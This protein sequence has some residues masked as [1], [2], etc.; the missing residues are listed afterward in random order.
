MSGTEETFHYTKEDLR[1]L[2]SRETKAHGGK[3]P[4]DAEASI[5]KVSMPPFR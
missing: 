3:I 5:M 4:K 2:E 1:K